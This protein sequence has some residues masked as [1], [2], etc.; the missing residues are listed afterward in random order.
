MKTF[1]I[2]QT[3]AKTLRG[4]ISFHENLFNH[5]VYKCHYWLNILLGFIKTEWI[6]ILYCRKQGYQK[7]EQK[8][9]LKVFL[10]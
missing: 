9:H 10:A 5:N 4:L 3:W 1:T 8:F 7:V 2:R 6:K